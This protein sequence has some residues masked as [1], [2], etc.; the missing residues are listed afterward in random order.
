MWPIQQIA[1]S[2]CCPRVQLTGKVIML[3]RLQQ[4]MKRR[5]IRR[6]LDDPDLIA[7]LAAPLDRQTTVLM[8]QIKEQEVSS[9][10]SGDY[11]STA[12]MLA[13]NLVNNE[14]MDAAT[15][16]TSP[17]AQLLQELMALLM[18]LLTGCIP[19]PTPAKVLAAIQ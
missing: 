8:S 9:A 17:F 1:G 12:T 10:M 13:N 3:N 18:P 5:Q 16:G 11:A 15:V 14:G 6:F 19:A 7:T 4:G 2:S